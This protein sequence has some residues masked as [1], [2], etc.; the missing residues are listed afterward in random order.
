MTER[1]LVAST[2][3]GK[4]AEFAEALAGLGYQVVTIDETEARGEPAPDETG[5][6]FEENAVLKARH[7]HALTGLLTVADDS[8]L[9]VD[10]LAGRPGLHSARYAV[11]D[12]SRIRRLLG[13]LEGVPSAERTARF[14]CAVALVGP[15]IEQ[16]FRGE[17]RGSIRHVASGTNGFGFD[18]VFA[19]DGDS[20][21]FAEMTTSEK[22]RVSHRGQ[23]ITALAEY[24][25]AR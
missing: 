16:V 25:R 1:L 2:N 21:T 18:P 23:A 14:V 17:C 8:G 3:H 19:P 11:D 24:M 9:E 6:T 15:K 22:R 13:E 12:A 5:R 10:I 4:A 7:F 20:R